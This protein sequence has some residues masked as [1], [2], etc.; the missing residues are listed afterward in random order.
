[1][2]VENYT[3]C[4]CKVLN[5]SSDTI[6]LLN[7]VVVVIYS[8]NPIWLFFCNPR[9][10]SLPGSSVHGISQPRIVE[11]IAT[12]FSWGSSP[13]GDQTHI[14]CTAGR[15]F[16]TETSGKL[17]LPWNEGSFSQEKSWGKQYRARKKFR[18]WQFISALFIACSPDIS[19]CWV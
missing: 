13:P 8:L 4:S 7:V 10:C 17:F 14:S 16:T 19:C 1:M 2:W 5:I 9:D 11:W 12:S 6:Q 3:G 15:F 18:C